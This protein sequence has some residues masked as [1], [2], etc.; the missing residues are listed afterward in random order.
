MSK[1]ILIN[2]E[3]HCGKILNQVLLTFDQEQITLGDLL[4]KRIEEE[5]SNS[6]KQNTNSKNSI[7]QKQNPHAHV[8]LHAFRENGFLILVNNKEV[9]E[10]DQLIPIHSNLQIRF[11]ALHPYSV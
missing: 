4:K 10:L 7:F 3:T 9:S 1:T 2:D 11:V 6:S 5:V 8:A